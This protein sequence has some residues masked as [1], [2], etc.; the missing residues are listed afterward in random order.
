MLG[1]SETPVAMNTPRTKFWFLLE[2]EQSSLEKWWIPGLVHRK[3]KS[4]K[5]ITVP[6]N[7]E[8]VKRDKDTP[9]TEVTFE[10]QNNGTFEHQYNEL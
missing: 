3:Y 7:K 1:S 8:V 2:R 5:Y 6:E 9:N 10:N 4:L